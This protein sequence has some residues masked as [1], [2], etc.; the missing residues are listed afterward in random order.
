MT[1]VGSIDTPA[2]AGDLIRARRREHGLSQLALAEAA[3]VSRKFIVDLEAGH[4]RAEL[5]K[6][7]AVL[8]ALGLSL[9][10]TEPIPRG[11]EYD[12]ARR[13]YATTFSQL[14][15]ARDFEF[16]I[17]MLAEY[18]T[19]SLKAG[20]PLLHRSPRLQEPHWSAAL[21]GITNYTAHRLGQPAP[22]WT[23]RIR[24][25]TEAW[26]PAESYRTVREPMKKLTMSETPPELAA[27]NVF[28]RERSLATA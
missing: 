6:T 1:N 10:A 13:D 12:P 21:A 26:L 20:R 25:L 8:H 28:I 3:G 14:I 5:G 7:I 17:K 24:P 16:A 11:S 4:E 22:L 19:A 2:A 18:A 15:G 27:M 9:A 23:R